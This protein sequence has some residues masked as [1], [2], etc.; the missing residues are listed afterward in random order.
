MSFKGFVLILAV[1]IVQQNSIT[2]NAAEVTDCAA[3]LKNMQSELA[4]MES[5]H[6]TLDSLSDGLNNYLLSLWSWFIQVHGQAID[7]NTSANAVDRA[8]T[9]MFQTSTPALKANK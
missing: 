9:L 7:G 3:L 5:S 8:R 4:T 1:V 2:A 6:A